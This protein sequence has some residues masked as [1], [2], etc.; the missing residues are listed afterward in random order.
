MGRKSITEDKSDVVYLVTIRPISVEGSR[1]L[2]RGKGTARSGTALHLGGSFELKEL[3]LRDRRRGQPRA[4]KGTQERNF[5]WFECVIAISEL[6][7]M[8][9]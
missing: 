9:K 5:V 6:L 3:K 7:D 1:N 8:R 4:E 2:T